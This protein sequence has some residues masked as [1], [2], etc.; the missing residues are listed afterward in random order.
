[1]KKFVGI[2]GVFMFVLILSGCD[3]PAASAP[4]A[5]PAYTASPTPLF[6]TFSKDVGLTVPSA[7]EATGTGEIS[8]EAAAAP[9]LVKITVNGEVPVT[10]QKEICYFCVETIHI[11]PNLAVPVEFFG[12]LKLAQD[13][14]VESGSMEQNLKIENGQIKQPAEMTSIKYI[15]MIVNYPLISPIA[16][17]IIAGEDGATLR[18]EGTQFFLVDG[19][20]H[21]Q[22]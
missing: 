7:A 21:L 5:T 19:S 22:K 6:P 1:M 12:A 18:K 14:V 10:N 17:S 4:T 2:C 11:A 8:F 13:V 16:N 9:E 20:A 15:N 3:G